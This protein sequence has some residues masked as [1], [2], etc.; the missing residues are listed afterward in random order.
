MIN[1]SFD[2]PYLLLLLIPMLAFVLIPYFIAVRKE[3][4]SKASTIA[5]VL[6]TVIVILVV[7]A[8]AG[9]TNTTVITE[10]E[11]YVLADLSHSTSE[12]IDVIDEY[13][14][15]IEDELPRNSEMGVITFGKDYKLHTPI[16]EEITSVR[17]STVDNSATDIV[18]A[19]RYAD[20]LFGES[21]IKR[22]VLITDGLSTDPE[23]TGELIRVI[24]DMKANGVHV[25][26]VYIDSN[27]ADDVKEIQVSDVQFNP[28]TY[29]GHDTTVNVMLES[30]YDTR[31]I[32]TLIKD[33]EV[34]REKT[35]QLTAGY[36]IVNFDI[37]A[38]EEG[39]YNYSVTF[40]AVDDSSQYNNTI[41]FTQVVNGKVNVLVVTETEEDKLA[42]EALYGN[43]AVVTSCVKPPL[44]KPTMK[45]PYPRPEK[46]VVPYTVEDLCYY[47]EI[48]LYNVDVR[49]I[50]NCDTFLS[51]LDT[52]VSVFGKSLITAGNNQ[53]QNKDDASLV[54]LKNMLPV[55]F[56]NEDGDPKLYTLVIDSSRS[57]EF[58]NADFFVMAKKAAEYLLGMLNEEDYFAIIHFSGEVYPLSKPQ[59]A[60]E[61]NVN[62]ALAR[63][64]AVDV[65][66]GTMMGAALDSAL[67]MVA[68]LSY[69]DKQIML[70]SDGMSFEGGEV[71]QDDPISS[72]K[73]LKANNVTVSTLNTG[74]TDLVGIDTM[75]SIA[76]AG[77]GN[78]YFAASSEELPG[79]MFT[80]I[81]DDITETVIEKETD[82]IVK[83]LTDNVLDGVDSL[84]KIYGYVYTKSKASAET[85]LTAEYVKKGGS[86]VEVP[87]YAYWSYG[88]GKVA[89]LTT[90]IDG[91]W[92]A[93]WQDE[94][95]ECFLLNILRTNTPTTRTD[96]PYTIN[97]EYDGK[98][99]HVEIIP[100]VLNP[101]ATMTVKVIM[102]D[103][104]ELVEKLTFDSYR[105]FYKFETGLTGKYRVEVVYD[106]VTKSYPSTTIFDI[107]YSPEYDSF[108]A[109][110]P[111]VI[112]TFMRNNGNVFEGGDVK[113]DVDENEIATYVLRF[114][115]P[116]LALAAILYVIDT[117]IRKL[118]WADIKSF[119]KIRRKESKK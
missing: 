89:T 93:D 103:G 13:I 3:N 111:A 52:V 110:T 10:T 100:I 66:Q 39:E 71:L 73:S 65:T 72:A 23:A 27:I 54:A 84:G 1:I 83:R 7:F 45:D 44:P 118:K 53:I 37:E 36:N 105:Y 58:K 48:I 102:P 32:V 77:G 99:S 62:A 11:L 2:N 61:E 60:T 82:I 17:E 109:Y 24:G 87:I 79:V 15:G 76:A 104:E 91:D 69:S 97:I 101:D 67:D 56:G 49:G 86:S 92:V 55:K 40:T 117:V 80:E 20:S 46:F 94:D 59:Q 51:S 95:G 107:S 25:D 8:V 74:N 21:S 12:D 38:E 26:A 47:D 116:F 30:T 4:K 31:A 75:K 114:T 43:N 19:L 64:N 90:S 85:I 113:L 42:L 6:H 9:M 28:S 70:I 22:V 63:L 106:L 50:D 41:S 98:N 68:G 16:G 78:Y 34:Y 57:M 33:G 88:N 108:T 115:V 119:F 35:E 96:Y 112:H 81:A 18:S 14:A 5:L 29:L